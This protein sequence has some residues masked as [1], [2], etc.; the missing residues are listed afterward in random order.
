MDRTKIYYLHYGDNVP[1]YV[2]KT[3]SCLKVRLSSHKGRYKNKNIY[4]EEIDEILLKDWKFWECYWIEQF[5]QWGF[6]LDNKNEGGGGLK[7]HSKS[8]KLK[9]S[10]SKKG[11][12][13]V[14]LK[15]RVRLDISKALKGKKRP[16]LSQK[17]KGRISPMKGKQF[18]QE[19]KQKIKE[20]RGFLKFR[21]NTWQSIPVE[22]YDLNGTFIRYFDS[23][24]EASIFMEIKGDGVGMCCRGKQKTAYG[25]IWKFKK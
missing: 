1:I 12:S 18:S 17:L 4:I 11:I 22:Q 7:E 13:N 9:I 25:Y 6:I 8:T 5:K 20:S 21:Q 24:K 10:K 16:D 14:A 15:G 2:G 23:Q 19:H 3:N